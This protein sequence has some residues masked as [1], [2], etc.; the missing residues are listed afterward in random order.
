MNPKISV[1]IAAYNAETYLGEALESILNQQL[2][3]SEIIVVD[4]GSADRTAELIK[5][6]FPTIKYFFQENTGFPTA[7]NLGVKAAKGEYLAFLDAD[8]IWSANKLYL[9]NLALIQYPDADMIFGM[10]QQFL[11]P[12]LSENEKEKIYFNSEPMPG[13]V[14]GTLF[15]RRELFIKT[16]LFAANLK[17]GAF[18][19]WYSRCLNNGLKS[20][21]IPEVV[22]HRRLHTF[23]ISRTNKEL[24]YKNYLKIVRSTIKAQ[25]K[26]LFGNDSEEQAI[27]L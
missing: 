9:Q 13:N 23:N 14:L 17:V 8:D 12:D 27:V 6:C 22:M 2:P 3:P 11:S 5:R 19:E 20:L 16:G 4:D 15:L 24:L 10:V 1:I 21:M 25:K 18:I 26:K 7:C